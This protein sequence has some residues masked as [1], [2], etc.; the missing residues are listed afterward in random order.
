MRRRTFVALTVLSALAAGLAL[1]SIAPPNVTAIRFSGRHGEFGGWSGIDL[2]DDGAR[3]WA[4]SDSGLIAEGRLVR[5]DGVLR[6]A[7][8]RRIT[9][10]RGE[11][12]AFNAYKEED[13]EGLAV[14]PDGGL[15]VS[16][17]GFHRV[18]R[19]A[20][21]DAPAEP[22]LP[23]RAFRGLPANESLEAVAVD[24]TG[25]ILTLPETPRGPADRY[26]VFRH[27]GAHWERAFA[28]S[29]DEGW[30]AV[31]A[32]FGPEGRFYLLERW[33]A[34]F[35]FASRIRRF[36]LTDP[37]EPIP[38]EVLYRSPPGRHGNLEGIAIWRDDRGRT[39]ATMIADDN[40]MPFQ[41]SQI[42]ELVLP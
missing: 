11:S 21:P 42:V 2:S 28:L 12:Q 25:A 4:V 9:T 19:Y 7:E 31:G 23:A 24:A 26:P 32:D 8:I 29:R 38:G 1:R 33:F 16:Y 36:D 14:L 10:L 40:F 13:S 39:R 17:E 35:G 41:R 22:I 20:G 34:G 27:A 6:R 18:W 3:F 5:R 30:K 37:A 15:V